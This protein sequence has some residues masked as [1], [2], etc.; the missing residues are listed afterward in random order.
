MR[1]RL[2][3]SELHF[4]FPMGC[5]SSSVDFVNTE[6]QT[7]YE[8]VET[9]YNELAKEEEID[10]VK[11]FLPSVAE[12]LA[13][14]TGR[15]SPIIL[16]FQNIRLTY[17]CLKSIYSGIASTRNMCELSLTNCR[18]ADDAINI[19]SDMLKDQH[20]LRKLDL[21]H[22]RIGQAG[23][24][25]LGQSLRT[26][27]TLVSLI[28]NHNPG[29]MEGVMHLSIA[30]R[31]N[32]TL[33]RLGLANLDMGDEGAC[34]IASNMTENRKLASLDI[35]GNRIGMEGSQQLVLA[36]E[37]NTTLKSIDVS[38]NPIPS[39]HMEI[40]SN[41]LERNVCVAYSIQ[42]ILDNFWK[43][44]MNKNLIA[45]ESTTDG[46]TRL[47]W[48]TPGQ[49]NEMQGGED[50]DQFASLA[51]DETYGLA[52]MNLPSKET[53]R[54]AAQQL[55]SLFGPFELPFLLPGQQ[56]HNA[57]HRTRKLRVGYADT[58][59][60]RLTM[61]DVIVIRRSFRER[62]D[63]DLLAV[64]DGHGGREASEFCG[65]NLPPILAAH[66]DAGQPPNVA[67][68]EAF[69]ETNQQ[70]SRYDINDGSTGAVCLITGD[71]IYCANAGDTRIV[72]SRKGRAVRL[73]FDHKADIPEEVARINALGGYVSDKRV[74]GILA[75]ARALGDFFL[76]PY[77]T[78]DPFLTVTNI[79][80]GDEFVIVACDG[81]WDVISD[82]LAC[83]I[84]ATD[85]D[86]VQAALKLIDQAFLTG[87]T[88]NIS[89]IVAYL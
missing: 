16:K 55:S 80:P 19:V 44:A 77:V 42:S 46:G 78:A 5:G 28:M 32:R 20:H 29:R 38:N 75:V 11:T 23:F 88:D 52:G 84:V 10:R 82:D 74:M 64:F 43:E 61:E 34:H 8:A 57:M 62:Q 70:M 24:I 22:N 59:G 33:T 25:L 81:V 3:G 73:T 37:Q 51:G 12:Q 48:I 4:F 17:I 9:T 35:S 87:S 76:H 67:L 65:E 30:L 36:I 56:R 49:K 15:Y 79:S 83:Q 6:T 85:S 7:F 13:T 60:R 14:V 71:K 40:I 41:V 47:F 68:R 63:E 21:S 26:N 53:I 2:W 72:L 58:I 50:L 86:P 66:L 18:L 45:E 69:L 1:V 31:L 54:F 27:K 89:V 39:N